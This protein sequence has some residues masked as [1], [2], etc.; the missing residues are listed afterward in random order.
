LAR[1]SIKYVASRRFM[2]YKPPPPFHIAKKYLYSE[3][4]V[5]PGTRGGDG[6]GAGTFDLLHI[7]RERVEGEGVKN[8]FGS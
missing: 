7:I 2:L 5:Q 4:Y 6:A 8:G 3:R 1:K